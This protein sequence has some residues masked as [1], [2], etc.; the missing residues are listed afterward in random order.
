MVHGLENNTEEDSCKKQACIPKTQW[1]RQN[2]FSKQE[3]V[4]YIYLMKL[5]LCLPDTPG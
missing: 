5:H 3:R 2:K 4:K 1:Y